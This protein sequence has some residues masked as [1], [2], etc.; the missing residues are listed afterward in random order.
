MM[1]R[2]KYL[3]ISILVFFLAASQ[4]IAANTIPNTLEEAFVELDR[5]LPAE[6]RTKFK[7]STE[8]DATIKAHFG[9]GMFIRNKWFRSGKSSLPGVL[10]NIGAR[11]MET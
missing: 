10:Q 4:V 1:K 5:L 9:L 11:H 7:N 2:L 6:E 8:R 3:V